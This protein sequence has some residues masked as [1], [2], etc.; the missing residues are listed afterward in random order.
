MGPKKS[1]EP[2]L[3]AVGSI[4]ALF[5]AAFVVGM[6]LHI[7]LLWYLLLVCICTRSFYRQGCTL[8]LSYIGVKFVLNT[9]LNYIMFLV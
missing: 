3:S 9:G 6:Y 8:I 1:M 2:F 7:W 5:K 4:L